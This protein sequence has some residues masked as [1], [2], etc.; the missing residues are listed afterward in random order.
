MGN[1]N[2]NNSD[3]QTKSNRTM[4]LSKDSDSSSSSSSDEG[5]IVV[6]KRNVDSKGRRVLGGR[7]V[8]P[9]T[10]AMTHSKA[11]QQ[12]KNNFPLRKRNSR[13]DARKINGIA[14]SRTTA[15]KTA[16]SKKA[17]S[18][19]R[20]DNYNKDSSYGIPNPSNCNDDNNDDNDD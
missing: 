18:I 20:E 17:P 4:D 3:I 14:S 7:K 8:I 6:Q 10:V 2:N 16:A 19:T 11:M 9:L 13:D 5:Y 1:N 12:T 15:P